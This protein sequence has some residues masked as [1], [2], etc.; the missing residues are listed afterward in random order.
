MYGDERPGREDVASLLGTRED[1]YAQ[2]RLA[3]ELPLLLHSISEFE[4]LITE[5]V[6]VVQPDRAIEIGGETGSSARAYLS[7]GV[8]EVITVDVA[9]TTELRAT[10]E[11]YEQ[12]TLV[13]ERSPEVLGS[14]PAATMWVVDGDHNYG[15]VHAELSAIL[16]RNASEGIDLLA[17]FHDV[18]WPCARRDQYYAPDALAPEQVRPHTWDLGATVWSDELVPDGFVG[19]G[20]YATALEAGGERNGV[21]TAIEDV[22]AGREDELELAI[23]PAVFGIGVL[24]S[25]R[26]PWADEV[27]ALLRPWDRSG[28]LLRLESNRLALFLRVLSLQRELSDRVQRFER[29][30]AS[31]DAEISRLRSELAAARAAAVGDER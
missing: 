13:T 15:V 4:E 28:L 22:I 10:A 7:A 1:P 14:L 5:L 9:P 3:R 12:L 16:D 27:R 31:L 2:S 21:L 6:R 23:V 25:K 19:K 17:V 26:A 11:Q 18:L 29:H 8:P 30:S 20:A 24:F